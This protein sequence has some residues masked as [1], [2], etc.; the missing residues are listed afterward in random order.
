MERKRALF[1]CISGMDV[2]EI[3]F[4]LAAD[5]LQQLKFLMIILFQRQTF[6]LREIFLQNLKRK[7][8]NH[9]IWMWHRKVENH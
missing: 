7:M 5:L 8:E 1:L 9:N 2:Q 3:Y 4:T 6:L